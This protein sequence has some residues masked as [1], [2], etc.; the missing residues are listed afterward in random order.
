MRLFLRYLLF[1][2]LGITLSSVNA[3]SQTATIKTDQLDYPPGS[4]A[5]ITG[6]G[7]QPNETVTL[8]VLHDPTGGDDATSPAHQPWTVVADAS[9][10]VSSTW[11][12][13]ADEDELGATL[14]LSAVG[15]TSGLKAAWTFTDAG[16][17]FTI[18]S[19]S[20]TASNVCAGSTN[21]KIH[22]FSL[23]ASSNPNN[24]ASV[25]FTT[26][27]NYFVSDI[28]NFKLY[29]TTNNTFSTNNLLGTISPTTAG[30]QTFST[31][32][33]FN[34]TN[35]TTYY[36]WITMDVSSVVTDGHNLTVATTSS[37]N[38]T[39][40]SSQP[41][42]TGTAS[43]S[44]TQTL[45]F[46]AITG[47]PGNQSVTYGANA[48][49]TVAANGAGT[50]TYQWQISTNS[51]G[52]W[53]ALS[54]AGVYSN[55]TTSTLNLTKPTVIMTG[56][57]YRCIVTGN[58]SP[59]NSD[60]KATLTVNKKDITGSFT[61]K[62]KP[63][64][65]TTSATVN[66]ESPNG[67]IGTDVVTLTGGTATFDTKNVGTGKTV[68][69]TG[70]SLSGADAGNYNLISVGTTTANITSIGITGSFT[71]KN[72]PYDAT[73]SATV[74]SESP[75]GI[76]GT[77]VVNL[78]GGTATFDTKNVGTGKTVTLTGAS[79]SGADA[80]NYNLTSVG[81][82]TANITAKTINVTAQHDSRVYNGT[83]ISS[84]APVVDAL[85][86]GDLVV[87][88][89]TQSYNNK[90][91]GTGKTLTATGLVINDGNN[92]ANYTVTYVTDL[93]GAITAKGINVTAQPDSRVYNGTASSS[94]APVVD[95]LE[96]GDLVTT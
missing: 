67:I 69:L 57:Q 76:I 64:D 16:G 75:N 50:L 77:D 90:N 18:G 19:N 68:T 2:L 6:K 20:I 56:Y 78:T 63:Y 8:Q 15:E 25:S 26:S 47:Q 36:L 48:S 58:C 3:F 52:S 41:T 13:P 1:T 31:L 17:K 12:V 55:V 29:I 88:A 14:L 95:A 23:A 93:T 5:I 39:T 92:G 65:A 46:T 94:V 45:Q 11:I 79:L 24:L 53:S 21:A 72:K 81:T 9:G 10:N 7:F 86:T 30:L 91:V 61:A 35:N 22:S 34:I 43:A 37:S 59:T 32:N 62:N 42:F 82:T 73:T 40:T 33:N 83:A 71:A 49:F 38:I 4:T 80:G 85:E 70:A 44:G 96:T 54:N 87:T 74:N 60:G 51:G 89:P 84:V 66:S 27:G 28:V